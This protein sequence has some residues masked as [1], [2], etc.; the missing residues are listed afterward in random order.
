MFSKTKTERKFAVNKPKR[1]KSC[2]CIISSLNK[3]MYHTGPIVKIHGVVKESIFHIATGD[4]TEQV[5]LI[6]AATWPSPK[7]TMSLLDCNHLHMARVP[8]TEQGYGVEMLPLLYKPDR[9]MYHYKWCLTQTANVQSAGK[10]KQYIEISL[11][12]RK[13]F[14]CR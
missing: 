1:P 11:R 3:D 7:F 4:L 13:R 8:A 2:A 14:S 9:N 12:Y 10:N 6:G 5:D